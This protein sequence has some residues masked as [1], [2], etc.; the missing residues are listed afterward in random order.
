MAY[1][2][3]TL[4]LLSSRTCSISLV[5]ILHTLRIQHRAAVVQVVYFHTLGRSETVCIGL[6]MSLFPDAYY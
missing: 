1:L 5:M 3:S 6:P 4:A 2:A